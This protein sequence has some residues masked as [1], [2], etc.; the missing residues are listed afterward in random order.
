VNRAECPVKVMVATSDGGHWVQMRRILPAFAGFE[1]VFVGT[2]PAL[3]ADLEALLATDLAPDL[4]TGLAGAR[5]Y[6]VENV[7]RANAHRLPLLL[8]QLARAVGRERPD[9]IVTT[10]AAPGLVALALGRLLAR[11]R[12]VWIDSVANTERM[13][14]SGR[15]ARHVADAWLVQWEHLARPEGPHYWGAVL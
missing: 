12:T 6:R 2:E 9:A 1:L 10:G 15:M 7:S 5:Y 13:S 3:D 11:S 8:W 4:A 14:L